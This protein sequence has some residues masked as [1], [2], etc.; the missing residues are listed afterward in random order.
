M[1]DIICADLD[2][3]VEF[4]MTHLTKRLPYEMYIQSAGMMFFTL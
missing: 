4:L 2:L 3:M 1:K